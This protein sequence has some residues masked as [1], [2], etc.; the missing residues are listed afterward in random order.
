MTKLKNRK[1]FINELVDTFPQIKSEVF[2]ED[3]KKFISLQIGCFRHFTQNAIDTGDL[4]TVKKCFE[5]VDKNFETVVFEIE[6]SLMISYL[7][8]LNIAKGSQVDKLLPLK[9]KNAKEVLTSYYESP[10]KNERA[11]K[12]LDDIKDDLSSF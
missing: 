10:S 6:N 5:F 3:Y 1:T 12:F 8:K 7:G 4:K 2:D 11:N 9:L